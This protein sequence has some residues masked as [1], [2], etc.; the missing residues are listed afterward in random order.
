MQ[1]MVV[2]SVPG[3]GHVPGHVQAG[4]FYRCAQWLQAFPTARL[5]LQEPS[6]G[7]V[8]NNLNLGLAFMSS[9][10]SVCSHR[11]PEFKEN[12]GYLVSSCNKQMKCVPC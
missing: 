6:C 5:L 4:C 7:I 3:T 8:E 9:L 10:H 11:D 2:Q 1:E 12:L